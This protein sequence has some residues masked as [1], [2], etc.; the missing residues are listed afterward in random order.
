MTS[1]KLACI[2]WDHES[3]TRF[4]KFH[5]TAQKGNKFKKKTQKNNNSKNTH[6]CN[7]EF[8]DYW[9][10]ICTAC[11]LIEIIFHTKSYLHL[12]IYWF[13]AIHTISCSVVQSNVLFFWGAVFERFYDYK[14]KTRYFLYFYTVYWV[15][16]CHRAE[17]G[18][19]KSNISADGQ[20]QSTSWSFMF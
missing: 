14:Y 1:N 8:P 5:G 10:Y 20:I 3:S 17:I 6:I 2:M 9:K 15:I 16:G 7:R 12:C 11:A 18:H 13:S 19:W 4:E